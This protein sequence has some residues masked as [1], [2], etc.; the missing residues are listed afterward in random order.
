MAPFVEFFHKVKKNST[1]Y[2]STA[3]V[4]VTILFIRAVP[5]QKIIKK[6]GSRTGNVLT[7]SLKLNFFKNVVTFVLSPPPPTKLTEKD[8]IPKVYLFHKNSF[9]CFYRFCFPCC[10]LSSNFMHISA[11][12]RRYGEAQGGRASPEFFASSKKC[13]PQNYNPY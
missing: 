12:R 10:V 9:I 4:Y 11:Q 6:K 8:L 2:A 1:V 5:R 13:W 3:M 7:L